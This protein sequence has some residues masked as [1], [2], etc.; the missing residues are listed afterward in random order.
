MFGLY[1][2]RACVS[3]AAKAPKGDPNQT[4]AHTLTRTPSSPSNTLP[5]WRRGMECVVQVSGGTEDV[6]ECRESEGM[7]VVWKGKDEANTWA[8][9]SRGQERVYLMLKTRWVTA[10]DRLAKTPHLGAVT[11]VCTLHT[12]TRA[13]E[14]RNK[15]E[16]LTSLGNSGE[17]KEVGKA[18]QLT[19]MYDGFHHGKHTRLQEALYPW[20]ISLLFFGVPEIQKTELKCPHVWRDFKLIH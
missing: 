16:V 2:V 13:C 11:H 14:N 6:T 15:V 3:E 10:W 1:T 7:L 18:E 17:I 20:H 8:N 19:V 4:A 9:T 12:H 5:A